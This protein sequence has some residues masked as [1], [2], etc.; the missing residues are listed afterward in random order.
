MA[1]KTKP[2]KNVGKGRGKIHYTD[3]EWLELTTAWM[4]TEGDER[5]ALAVKYNTTDQT[6]RNRAVKAGLITPN[7][8]SKRLNVIIN[9]DTE[10]EAKIDG[11]IMEMVASRR[12]EIEEQIAELQAEL[13]KLD[14]VSDVINMD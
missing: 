8:R 6:L 9:R 7:V 3:E 5:K 1:L 10:R 11:S 2:K 12:I 14:A 13:T 4:D